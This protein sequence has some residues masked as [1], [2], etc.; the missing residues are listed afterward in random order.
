MERG[1]ESK[2]ARGKDGDGDGNTGRWL[3]GMMVKEKKR[4]RGKWNGG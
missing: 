4:E 3:C 1:K 2:R